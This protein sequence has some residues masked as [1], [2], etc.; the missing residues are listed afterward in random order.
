MVI[1]GRQIGQSTERAQPTLWAIS[2]LHTGHPGNKPVTESLY[3]SSPDDWLIVAGDVAER[4]DEIRWA[5]DLLRRRFAKVI[6]VPG[7]HELWTTSKDPMQIFGRARYDYLVNMCD[8]MGVVTPEHPFPVWTERGGP[9][10]I[11]PM[12]L[13]YDYTF[14][15]R[16]AT[17]KAEGLAIARERNVVATDEFLLS[18]EPYATREAWCRD[19][20]A[21]TRARLERARL[22][23]ADRPGQPFPAGPRALRRA[24]LPGVLA[25]VRN[26]RDRRLAHP[27]QR[28]LFGL[29]PPAHPA[30]HLVRRRALR[31]G[32]GGLPAGVAPPQALSLAAPGAARPAVRARAT[33][34]TSAG[35]SSITPEMR[36]QSE[37]FRDRLRQRQSR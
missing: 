11:V 21:Y 6:W 14:L 1:R 17:T 5:L 12:F 27:L 2:D 9:A 23:D 36:E 8:E 32:V 34:T 24:V 3:P 18:S 10:T 29:R 31:G 35:T 15:P 4:T 33:S 19:R 30:H 26:H 37:K 22:D 13:L 20:L 25:V 28:G 16:G 7:N